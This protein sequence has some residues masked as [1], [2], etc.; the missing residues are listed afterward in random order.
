LIKVFY[1]FCKKTNDIFID[2]LSFSDSFFLLAIINWK[3]YYRL[4]S[5]LLS[6]KVIVNRV[7]DGDTIVVSG[8][9]GDQV[10][11]RLLGINTPEHG[12]AISQDATDF[13]K[14]E[15]EGKDVELLRDISDT[16]QYKRKLRYIFYQN[17][18]INIDIVQMGLAPTLMIKGLK[19]EEKLK[20]AEDFARNNKLGL[21]QKSKDIC[22][23][24]IKLDQLDYTNEYFILDN[25][26]S[27]NCE[28]K[29]WFVK[30]DANHF[31]YLEKMGPGESV[32]YL[33]AGALDS[34]KKPVKGDIWNNDG[35]RFFMR[36]SNGG[37]VVFYEYSGDSPK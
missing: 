3:N 17:K 14:K 6:R 9:I 1:G 16:D 4:K 35:D 13:L 31:F 5:K 32:K 24:C 21:W 18:L 15:I 36:D 8:D 30:D 33:S 28:L 29:G 2:Y 34:N 26:C 11:I 20:A 12:Q 22:S 27:F 25:T 23:S 10:H 19:Y 7:I 37:L